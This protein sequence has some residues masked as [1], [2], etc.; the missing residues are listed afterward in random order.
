[1]SSLLIVGAGGH[2]KVVA[3]AAE[4]M[5]KW[6][7]I[8]F[9][10]DSE[11]KQDMLFSDFMVVGKLKDSKLLFLDYKNLIVAIGDNNLR[12]QMAK[13]FGDCGFVLPSIIHPNSIVS[14]NAIVGLGSVIF[15]GAV[16]N[17]QAMIEEF[18]IINTGAIIE[19]D[20]SI[21]RGSHISPGAVIG[22]GTNI[23]RKTWIGAG[24]TVINNVKIGNNVI[25]G[26]G[27]V[28]ISNIPDNSKWVGVPA[29]RLE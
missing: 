2:G 29:R 26:A 1:M 19:H 17:S 12:C 25:I 10:D 23:G 8:A 21:G 14:K 5:G 6:E 28:V 9:L 11:E 20:V 24:A 16:I 15:P 18:C 4:L 22:G 27:A 13:G 3:E 7:R